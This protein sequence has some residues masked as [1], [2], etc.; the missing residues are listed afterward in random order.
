M[1]IARTSSLQ[2][3]LKWTHRTRQITIDVCR[4]TEN[5]TFRPRKWISLKMD[6]TI[7]LSVQKMIKVPGFM[8]IEVV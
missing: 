3:K 4:H 5:A 6:V 2:T 1:M 8:K 7:V